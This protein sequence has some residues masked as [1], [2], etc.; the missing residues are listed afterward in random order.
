MYAL[1]GTVLEVIRLEA[2]IQFPLLL[3][4]LVNFLLEFSDFLFDEFHLRPN[5]VA[6]IDLLFLC[7]RILFLQKG[8]PLFRLV[9][10]HPRALQCFIFLLLEFVLV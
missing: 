4:Q 10:F 8:H 9:I 2:T 3:L 7:F 6:I 1:D 5:E